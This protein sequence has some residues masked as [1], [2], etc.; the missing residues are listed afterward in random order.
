MQE[1]S[2]VGMRCW[3]EGNIQLG[4]EMLT[5]QLQ[6]VRSIRMYTLMLQKD[7]GGSVNCKIVA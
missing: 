7:L 4:T 1:G 5:T 3:L 6:A 2:L